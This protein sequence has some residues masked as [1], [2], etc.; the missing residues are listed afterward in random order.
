MGER[1][2]GTWCYVIHVV[3]VPGTKL[4]KA[5]MV[6]GGEAAQW[7]MSLERWVKVMPHS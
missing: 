2:V 3:N 7:K 6:S 4:C 5:R 1:S